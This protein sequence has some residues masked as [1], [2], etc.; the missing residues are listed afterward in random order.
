[1]CSTRPTNKGHSGDDDKPSIPF[2]AIYGDTS[3]T[4][5][6]GASAAAL[7]LDADEGPYSC[8]NGAKSWQLGWY[9]ASALTVEPVT[10]QRGNKGSN[11]FGKMVGVDDYDPSGDPVVVKV[12]SGPNYSIEKD[13]YIMFNRAAGINEHTREGADKVLVTTSDS[14]TEGRT[15]STLVAELSAGDTFTIPNFNENTR[16]NRQTD[17]HITAIEINTDA[18]PAYARV[19]V[20][21]EC[22]SSDQCNDGD[23]CTNKSCSPSSGICTYTDNGTC[24]ASCSGS[25]DDCPS[26]NTCQIG[27]C[28]EG[29]CDLITLQNC[30]ASNAECND[31]NL[32]TDDICQSNTCVFTDNETCETCTV[33][34]ECSVGNACETPRCVSNVCQLDP[35]SACCLTNADC[36]DGVDCTDD[37]CNGSNQCTHDD[38]GCNSNC[39][40]RG[41]SCMSQSCCAGLNCRGNPRSRTCK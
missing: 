13:Y 27:V 36:N 1:M 25:G 20:Y 4:M 23:S 3:G 17:V 39:A 21:K 22:G 18:N 34:T 35:I 9:S 10:S 28:N 19:G 2:E 40:D 32:C 31:G 38:S 11:W 6:Y 37:V 24:Q 15:T 7:N 12:Q 14:G 8:F 26:G 41:E 5:G 29:V 16:A 30:C 33:D